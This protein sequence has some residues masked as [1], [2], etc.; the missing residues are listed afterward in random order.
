MAF[1]QEINVGDVS[2][3]SPTFKYAVLP[4]HANHFKKVTMGDSDDIGGFNRDNLQYLLSIFPFLPNLEELVLSQLA[5]ESLLGFRLEFATPV[6]SN[7]LMQSAFKMTATRFRKLSLVE[8][9][10][11]AA[12]KVLDWFDNV[13]ELTL[14]GDSTF[15]PDGGDEDGRT[16]L[17]DKIVT[18]EYLDKI[19]VIAYSRE[20]GS[21]SLESI[22]TR[23]WRSAGTL[24]D[25]TFYVVELEVE[26]LV[27]LE[28]LSGTL[29]TLS[30]D[31][32]FI[33][34]EA[35]AKLGST[36][37]FPRLSSLTLDCGVPDAFTVLS[38]FSISPL[39]HLSVTVSLTSIHTSSE[40]LPPPSFVELA[41]AHLL[42]NGHLRSLLTSLRPSLSSFKLGQNHVCWERDRLLPTLSL[43]LS[44]LC[45]DLGVVRASR[46][47]NGPSRRDPFFDEVDESWDEEEKK[48]EMGMALGEVER[49]LQFGEKLRKR[50][51]RELDREG[52]A[53][54]IESLR[55]LKARFELELD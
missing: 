55:S 52:L 19:G 44:Q 15:P 6:G 22:W 18:L 51:E 42:P 53:A 45:N 26:Q 49:V 48:V 8:F 25:V 37:D 41:L 35:R 12:A 27:F 17:A 2:N 10:A 14:L 9:A 32:D 29:E 11:G 47:A 38:A 1:E 5:I 39:R 54:L 28:S 23:E 46:G 20:V 3:S 43:A 7:L 13:R 21:L 50:C 30:L 31:F 33:T 16:R 34:D 24:K 40:D 4:R 36:V